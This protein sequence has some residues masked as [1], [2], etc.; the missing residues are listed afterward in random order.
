VS[1][2][3]ITIEESVARW[4]AQPIELG[5]GRVVPSVL[6][7]DNIPVITDLLQAEENVELAVLSA[8]VHGN[9]NDV[10]CAARIAAAAIVASAGLDEDRATLYVDLILKTLSEDAQRALSSMKPVKWEYM[11][12]FARHYDVL[13]AE[14]LQDVLSAI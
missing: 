6:G 9:D 1:L 14:S 8:V 10:V 13:R 3:I 5:A 12:E 4:A 2:V 7:P 11:S